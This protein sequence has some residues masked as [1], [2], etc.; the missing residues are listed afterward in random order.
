MQLTRRTTRLAVAALAASLT[1]GLAQLPAPGYGA[2]GTG[3]PAATLRTPGDPVTSLG[4]LD[5]RG[6][7]LPTALQRSAARSLDAQVRW[8]D[9]GTPASI[10]SPGG[11]L[12]RAA[13]TDP[14][15]AAR[16]WLSAHRDVLGLS[17]A[18]VDALQLV[19]YQQL[20]RSSARAVLFR[21]RFGDLTPAVGS[22]VTVGVAGGR[23]VYVS[24][25]LTRTTG[26]PATPTVS[27]VAGLAG[28]RPGAR[29]GRRAHRP[30]RRATWCAAGPASPPTA[31]PSRRWPAPARWRWP[32]ARSARSS[33][34]TS[35]TPRA[36]PRSPTPC[37]STRSPARCSA[38]HN[39]V[40]SSSDAYSFSGSTGADGC[41]PKHPFE[42]TDAKT[43]RDR[44]DRVGAPPTSTSCS[45][46]TAP[47]ASC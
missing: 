11:S 3:D 39:Q 33:R 20:A 21:Q 18:Q 36:A 35:S 40:D 15:A 8:N 7:A 28:R 27:P 12:G 32:T 5:A 13:S 25:S 37:S 42:T 24:S 44:G 26:T 30:R 46:S 22:M 9:F 17:A 16:A 2:P 38:Q 1:T 14:V 4:D 34:P 29:A 47:T 43:Q 45:S 19:R 31:S 10:Y 23:I 41:G 6:T